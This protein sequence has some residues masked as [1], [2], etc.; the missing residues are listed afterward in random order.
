VTPSWCT[1]LIAS[2]TTLVVT[3]VP[4]PAASSITI[5]VSPN[6]AR[7]GQAVTLTATVAPLAA[8]GKVTFY[9]GVAVVGIAP[10]V[11]GSAT[12]TTASLA[13]GRAALTAYYGGDAGN[14]P[15]RSAE[16]AMSVHSV[17]AQGFQ[18]IAQTEIR[19]QVGLQFPALAIG[20]FNLDGKLDVAATGALPGAS[21]MAILLGNGDGT[22]Q[23]GR[24]YLISGAAALTA[25][26]NGDGRPDLAVLSGSGTV[27]IMLGNGDGTFQAPVNTPVYGARML[28]ADFNGDGVVDLAV[29]AGTYLNGGVSILLG[30]G[31]ATFNAS[32]SIPIASGAP[33]LAMADF[34][35]DRTPDLAVQQGADSAQIYLG[36][37]DGTFHSQGSLVTVA[38]QISD[39]AAGDF[40]GQG[41]IDLAIGNSAGI[42]LFEGNGDGTL[43]AARFT[44]IGRPTFQV[45]ASDIDGDGNL[46]LAVGTGYPLD[47]TKGTWGSFAIL[48]GDGSGGLT[49]NRYH[50]SLAGYERFVLGDLNGDGRVDLLEGFSGPATYLAL[51]P[52][53]LSLSLEHS[54]NAVQGQ[55]G[56]L[57]ASTVTNRG[58]A[59]S[60]GSLVE[61]FDVPDGLKI[62]NLIGSGWTC[63]MTAC[64]RDDSLAA[65]ASFPP[66]TATVS[67]AD[68]AAAAVR[69]TATIDTAGKSDPEPANDTATD[70]IIVLQRQTIVFGSLPDV[71]ATAG[72]I[73]LTATA[74]SG[75]AVSYMATGNCTV[76]GKTVTL[77]GI[78]TCTITASQSGN[79]LFLPAADLSRTFVIGASA[80]AVTLTLPTT[81]GVGM[82]V[83]LVAAVTPSDAQGRVS[84]YDGAALIGTAP[85][86][87]GTAQLLVQLVNTGSRRILARFIG[88]APWPGGVSATAKTT[89]LAQPAFTFSVTP[90]SPSVFANLVA[91]A[92]FNGDGHL[93]ILAIA[94]STLILS[95][96]N[97]DGSFGDAVR[98]SGTGPP[99]QAPVRCGVGDFN[100]DGKLDVAIGIQ[101]TGGGNVTIWLGRGD[102]TFVQQRAIVNTASGAIVSADWNGDGYADLAISHGPA[103]A[104]SVLL[105][106]GDGTFEAPIEYLVNGGDASILLT[107]ADLNGDGAADLIAVAARTSFYTNN[108][109]NVLLGRGDGTFLQPAG[110]VDDLSLASVE[111]G[112]VVAGDLNSDGIPDLAI[113]SGFAYPTYRCSVTTLLGNGDGTFQP[114]SRH[115]CSLTSQVSANGYPSGIAIADFTGDEKPDIAAL[116]T[117]NGGYM[118]VFAGKGDGT[119]ENATVYPFS[120]SVSLSPAA[121]GDFNGDGRVD[122]AVGG[123]GRIALLTGG[124]APALRVAVRHLG[125]FALNTTVSATI[126][127]SNAP[128]AATTNGTVTVTPAVPLDGNIM[129]LSG[130]GW[131]CPSWTCT[132]SDSLAGGS[133]YAPITVE[134]QLYGPGGTRTTSATVSGGGATGAEGRDSSFILESGAAGAVTS[135]NTVGTSAVSQPAIS[136]NDWVEIHGINL[137]PATTPA[138]GVNW[139]NA[140]DFGA[141]KVPTQL[142]GVSV[143]VS[144]K[145]AFIY[146]YCSSATNPACPTDQ[147]IAL[148]PPEDFPSVFEV[149]V[150]SPVGRI[151]AFQV[152]GSA[153]T[154]SFLRLGNSRYVIATNADH[155]PVGRDSL[156]PE[157]SAPARP[158]ETVLLWGVGFGMPLTTIEPGSTVQSGAMPAQI[159]CTLGA[160]PAPA[161]VALVSPGLYQVRLTVP[162]ETMIGNHP[163]S[164]VYA[165]V[166][167][168]DGGLIAVK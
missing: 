92:D 91:A 46:D 71:V 153:A 72:P 54:G 83:T 29:A 122:L 117:F 20:D 95:P 31:D 127:V 77:S 103:P 45:A 5:L 58:P 80:T 139:K 47:T 19:N 59:A 53:D 141:G 121:L 70:T 163:V 17:A 36:K 55:T 164:C 107:V 118:Q 64:S 15:A 62:T 34:N 25:D 166:S 23:L 168:P 76:S 137:V 39:I 11:L 16:S 37:G 26:F 18:S 151:Q 111:P 51:E 161:T 63:S 9:Q 48:N 4:A 108:R 52:A 123:P 158:G 28:V 105:S 12:L 148:M 135:V 10:L 150:K 131:N 133:A 42:S 97:G 89:V 61:S 57:L 101:T 68:R 67:V 60:T 162:A 165:G 1:I 41:R 143:T 116:Y 3:A 109:V 27:S 84:F 90:I 144:G 6:P 132:R 96:G 129:S 7:Y 75:L 50:D 22:F 110:W 85:V 142:N 94:P 14:P 156:Y 159:A 145:P 146:S 112:G 86:R 124:M 74:T 2:A 167:T 120:G 140:Q 40:R 114:P 35:G 102:G 66:V 136:P 147:I 155:P 100:A 93:D 43:S 138:T 8:T 44:A 78:G 125:A 82:P 130:P 24:K 154:P 113:Q 152:T 115:L 149:V 160:R 157:E 87:E 21:M 69:M 104:V 98:S 33:A 49:L 32:A 126:E 99:G 81:A 106:R 134:M 13:P 56:L 88:T 119:F 30:K 128:L 79:D 73:L 38:G 65:G